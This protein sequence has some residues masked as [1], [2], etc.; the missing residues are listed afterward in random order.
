MAKQ[1]ANFDLYIYDLLKEAGIEADTQGSN[2]LE[3]N[4]ALKT[5]SK[6][7]TGKVGFPEYCAVVGNF[8]LVDGEQ[9]RQIELMCTRNRWYYYF[10]V[11]RDNS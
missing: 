9:S 6:H 11:S 10:Y 1:E 3:I 4:N 5:A 2:V 8:V 7:Q